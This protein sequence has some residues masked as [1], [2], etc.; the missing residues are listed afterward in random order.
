LY[1]EPGVGADIYADQVLDFA[2]EYSTCNELGLPA[3]PFT[4]YNGIF[5]F[6]GR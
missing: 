4:E 2:A 6:E 3:P 5:Y 1:G